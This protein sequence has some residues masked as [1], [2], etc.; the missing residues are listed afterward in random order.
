MEKNRFEAT[1]EQK[2][3]TPERRADFR[4]SIFGTGGNSGEQGEI[5]AS[6]AERLAKD[7]VVSGGHKVVNGGGA[8]GVMGAASQGAKE[9]ALSLGREDLLP[10]GVVVGSILGKTSEDATIEKTDSLNER[11]KRLIDDSKACVVLYGKM[12]T[13]QELLDSMIYSA[14]E[15]MSGEER[16]P[17]IIADQSL[18]HL[19]LLAFLSK[20]DKKRFPN[21]AEN[22]YVV[23]SSD[24]GLEETNERISADANF[25]IEASYKQSL[26]QELSEQE[27]EKLN[28]LS[29]SN[30]IKATDNFEQGGGI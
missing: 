5:A 8:A 9:A 14:V 11:L 24:A 7:I 28:S 10:E 19:D 17:V 30:F 22:T 26:G 23:S 4:V 1:R 6:L 13:A 18:E 27:K 29:L 16:K 2:E 21:F 25:I 3:D 20:A 12:G 15:S